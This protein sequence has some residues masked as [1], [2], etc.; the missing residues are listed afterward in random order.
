MALSSQTAVYMVTHGHVAQTK[1]VIEVLHKTGGEK[2]HLYVADSGSGDEMYQML[3]GLKDEGKIHWLRTFSDNVGQNIGANTC[4]DAIF[5]DGQYEWIVCW[6]ADVEP[7]TRRLLKKLVR[8]MRMFKLAGVD[9]VAA[10]LVKGSGQPV[11]LSLSGD[12]I[13]FPYFEAEVLKGYVRGHPIS[14][15]K[16]WRF[17]EYGALA[18]GEANEMKE[19]AM[20][21]NLGCV[22]IQN[23]TCKHLGDEPGF[24]ERHVGY[25]L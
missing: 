1:R 2:H 11:P 16:D 17:N 14:I 19:R 25:G 8:A 9:V 22:V 3:N 21:L 5:E 18:M 13:G 10:P 24:I 7:K 4:L 12:D 6:S 23:L 20:A 15:F